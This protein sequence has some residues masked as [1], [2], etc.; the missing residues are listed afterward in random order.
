MIVDN[1]KINK[2]R[3]EL[4]QEPEEVKILING[5]ENNHTDV[6]HREYSFTTPAPVNISKRKELAGQ[7]IYKGV[8]NS[9]FGDTDAGKSLLATYLAINISEGTSTD[10]FRNECK[11]IKTAYLHIEDTVED[12]YSKYQYN[13][14]KYD[15][16]QHKNLTLITREMLELDSIKIGEIPNK[17]LEVCLHLKEQSHECIFIDNISALGDTA[18]AEKA[19]ELIQNLDRLHIDTP[20]IVG[21]TLKSRDTSKPIDL[22]NITGSSLLGQ[23]FKNITAFAMNEE[24]RYLKLLKCKSKWEHAKCLVHTL[25]FDQ[26]ESGLI[27][28]VKDREA[29]QEK[30]VLPSST[31]YA[32]EIIKTLVSNSTQSKIAEMAGVSQATISRIIR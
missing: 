15:F 26:L 20:V 5:I 21:H 27:I 32:I 4:R 19:Y 18:K 29:R 25:H 9:L 7:Y 23:L 11:P 3:E 24:Y 17:I 12:L 2:E 13:H 31:S 28:P 16:T 10:D 22:G 6:T 8:S 14:K 1:Q 30:N